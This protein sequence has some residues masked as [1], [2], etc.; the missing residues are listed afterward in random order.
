M[1]VP[2]RWIGN[3]M[4]FIV[5]KAE[6]VGNKAKMPITV[7]GVTSNPSGTANLHFGRK[8]SMNIW[9]QGKTGK[10]VLNRAIK[11]V[12][13]VPRKGLA[14]LAN[15]DSMIWQMDKGPTVTLGLITINLDAAYRER[16][17]YET[18]KL[19][20]AHILQTILH[21]VGHLAMDTNNEIAPAVFAYASSDYFPGYSR[22]I[23][24]FSQRNILEAAD[25]ELAYPKFKTL[26]PNSRIYNFG[27]LM[28]QRVQNQRSFMRQIQREKEITFKG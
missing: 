24:G 9:L 16:N 5:P 15:A 13:R 26:R 1:A 28:K 27:S 19:F 23:K 14:I 17:R 11:E 25:G 8:Y 4:R 2:N 22:M 10:L 21:E 18:Q 6:F 7:V 12:F 20:R 3:L